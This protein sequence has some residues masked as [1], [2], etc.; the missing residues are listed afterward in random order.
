[1]SLADETGQHLTAL[2]HNARADQAVIANPPG[3]TELERATQRQEAMARLD[4]RLA[5]ILDLLA[6]R[7]ACADDR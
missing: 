5:A 7:G 1:M 6:P 2:A 3:A 4:T